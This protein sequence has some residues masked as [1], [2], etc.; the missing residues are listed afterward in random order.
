MFYMLKFGPQIMNNLITSVCQLF[1]V[2]ILCKGGYM[3]VL[4]QSPMTVSFMTVFMQIVWCLNS[5]K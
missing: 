3:S 4:L 2:S 1:F 5:S